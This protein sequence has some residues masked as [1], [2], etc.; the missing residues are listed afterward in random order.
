M[1]SI[2]YSSRPPPEP[3]T[4]TSSPQFGAAAGDA[5]GAG[6]RAAARFTAAFRRRVTGVARTGFFFTAVTV[7]F[8]DA[9]RAAFFTEDFRLAAVRPIRF[10]PLRIIPPLRFADK[11]S[12]QQTKS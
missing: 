6:F 2:G 8:F 1:P 10:L 3:W 12:R 11:A 9:V 4:E 5:I 7:L